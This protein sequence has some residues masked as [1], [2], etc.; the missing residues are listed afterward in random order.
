MEQD[1]FLQRQKNESFAV[2]QFGLFP[3]LQVALWKCPR[4]LPNINETSI[5]TLSTL[6][7]L[8][9]SGGSILAV[10]TVDYTKLRYESLF[11]FFKFDPLFAESVLAYGCNIPGGNN[12]GDSK[13]HTKTTT[14]IC[15]KQ[16]GKYYLVSRCMHSFSIDEQFTV[17]KRF[18]RK[19]ALK[20][21]RLIH[22]KMFASQQEVRKKIVMSASTPASMV[23]E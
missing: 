17:T 16:S 1:T 2:D 10:F 23:L 11:P 12:E 21:S 6:C 18:L 14:V 20:L 5:L 8:L 7:S 19:T 15:D 13:Q 22:E 3:P 4:Q 9:S